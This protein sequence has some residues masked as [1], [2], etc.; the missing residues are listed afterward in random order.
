MKRQIRIHT[1]TK[2]RIGI[3]PAPYVP[4]GNFQVH[5]L[6]SKWTHLA[7]HLWGG[8]FLAI[9]YPNKFR[10]KS[11]RIGLIMCLLKEKSDLMETSCIASYMRLRV[12]SGEHPEA[13]LSLWGGAGLE[14]KGGAGMVESGL[15]VFDMT[16]MK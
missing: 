8:T 9:T 1:Y 12:H 2:P 14:G 16:K 7:S 6:Y 3:S 11:S 13:E 10:L 15:D 5:V 4:R